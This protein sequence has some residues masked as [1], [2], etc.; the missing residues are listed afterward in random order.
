MR[1]KRMRVFLFQLAL[2]S[3]VVIA[4]WAAS[5]D[6]QGQGPGG[7]G[8]GSSPGGAGAA[9]N[10]TP[11][12]TIGFSQKAVF[13][14]ALGVDTPT[15]ARIAN[16]F[17]ARLQ[18]KKARPDAGLPVKQYWVIPEGG[19]T[20]GDYLQQCARDPAHTVG[21]FIVLPPS[22]AQSSVNWIVLLETRTEATFSVI[23]AACN[24][25][26]VLPSGAPASATIAPGS[27]TSVVWASRP[28]SG[29]AGRSQ[30][31]IFPIAI[32]TSIYLAFAPQRTYQTTST[33]VYPTTN[34]VAAGGERS[35]VATQQATVLNGSGAGQIQNGIVTAFAG[36]NGGGLGSTIGAAG[37]VDWHYL[38]AADDAIGH[39]L[40]DDL[41]AYCLHQTPAAPNQ[42]VSPVPEYN[43]YNFCKW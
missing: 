19:W 35:N 17:A 15:A 9:D 33:V 32:L 6:A 43:P 7:G 25:N 38:H 36:S 29:K 12:P 39:L 27:N 42:L 14:L 10:K 37:S 16:S 28:A 26:P 34:P 5:A 40:K 8:G 20:L 21:A 4:A 30:V 24:P 23:V 22:S 13:T 31:E 2:V 18:D 11:Q 1:L 3:F 41:D